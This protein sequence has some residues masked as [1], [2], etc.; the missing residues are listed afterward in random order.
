MHSLLVD[1]EWFKNRKKALCI[2]DSDVAEAL[3]VER[4]VANKILNGR[5][6]VNPKRFDQMAALFQVSLDD[7]LFRLGITEQKPL[8]SNERLI[9]SS[10]EITVWGKVAAGVWMEES[11]VDPD[12]LRPATVPYDQMAGDFGTEH[13]FAVEPEGESM[14][15]A[16]MPGTILICRRVPFGVGAVES[17]DYV[18][19]ARENH[20]LYELT[21]KRIE[22]DENEDFLLFSESSNPKYAEP[23]KIPR[24]N[25]FEFFDGDVSVVGVV[26]RQVRDMT[27]RKK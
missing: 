21:C 5:V 26:I 11:P 10:P 23:I 17:G 13:L 22:L 7:L 6:A 25:D 8:A 20:G 24:S 16:F 15:L 9:Q 12:N 18:I 19:V 3:G 4:S 2:T 1:V 27:R 14:N